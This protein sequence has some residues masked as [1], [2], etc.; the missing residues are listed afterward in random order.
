MRH[1]LS[2]CFPVALAL[3]PGLVGGC[4]EDPSYFL[5]WKIA[6]IDDAS[7][8]RE[9]DSARICTEVGLGQLRLSTYK[10]GTN[11]LADERLVPCAA[12]EFPDDPRPGPELEDGDYDVRLEALRD[13]GGIWEREFCAASQIPAM[14]DPQ[15]P[16]NKGDPD[17]EDGALHCDYRDVALSCYAP[18]DGCVAGFGCRC[19]TADE[20]LGP[21]E[22]K[23]TDDDL[24]PC[25]GGSECS[26][27]DICVAPSCEGGAGCKCRDPGNDPVCDAGNECID[28]VCVPTDDG[29][30]GDVQSYCD[31]EPSRPRVV[32]RW[33]CQFAWDE[34][35]VTITEDDKP[36]LDP[37]LLVAPPQ[38]DD[39]VDN[40]ADGLTD[41]G[42]PAC[43]R[44]PLGGHEI[45]DKALSSIAAS[46]TFLDGNPN[47]KCA[48][49]GIGRVHL[50][51]DDGVN[52]P[53][54]IGDVSCEAPLTAFPSFSRALPAGTYSLRAIGIQ[55]GTEDVPASAPVVSEP[56]E[57]DADTGA[58]FKATLD[59]GADDLL[60]PL[61]SPIRLFFQFQ[62]T[63]DLTRGCMPASGVG[64]DVVLDRVV[65]SVLE[66]DGDGW[67][68]IADHAALM[69]DLGGL[70]PDVGANEI[71]I[72]CPNGPISSTSVGWGVYAVSARA[73]TTGTACFDLP[74]TEPF[75][76]APGD[77]TNTV[78]L[79][80]IYE[81]D[82]EMPP[83]ACIECDDDNDCAGELDCVAGVCGGP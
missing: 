18:P 17:D 63:Q 33:Y 68:P 83:M 56:F 64:G 53:E 78:T 67:A 11:V 60:E 76:L 12:P 43:L 52:E 54:L 45:D 26:S 37:F 34:T 6:P 30:C 4:A 40:D 8:A 20:Q 31:L 82:P 59:I 23:D 2:K 79:P 19:R 32:R 3:L 49:I 5:R 48:G 36:E 15:V 22:K 38:C 35:S 71:S 51:L 75:Q 10:A 28:K 57:V 72:D 47:V 73:Q 61:D 24:D 74:D 13:T 81:G 27:A 41:L 77:D 50:E 58:F 21:D 44:D 46:V 16:I 29:E 39:G 66:P 80:R 42:D 65:F 55:A 69:F 70:N 14:W 7:A 1:P 62:N 9:P 25:D